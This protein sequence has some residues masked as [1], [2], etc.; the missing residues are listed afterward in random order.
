MLSQGFRITP[1]H[2]LTAYKRKDSLLYFFYLLFFYFC[3]LMFH[4]LYR[5]P[6]KRWRSRRWMDG[7]MGEAANF[8]LYLSPSSGS[9]MT[10]KP[11]K[12]SVLSPVNG[13]PGGMD[14]WMDG[15][16]LHCSAGLFWIWSCWLSINL[17]IQSVFVPLLLHTR[18]SNSGFASVKHWL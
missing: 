14:G 11:I 15:R 8:G 10:A 17:S 18:W 5:W 16:M 12:S 6:C 4:C 3:L 9:P 2:S 7:W 13:S 1:V